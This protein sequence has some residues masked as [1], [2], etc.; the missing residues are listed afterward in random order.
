MK[1][2][3]VSKLYQDAAE[4]FKRFPFVILFSILGSVTMIS[5]IEWEPSGDTFLSKAT[6]VFALGI[7]FLLSLT[8]RS[9]TLNLS[10]GKNLLIQAAG[11]AFLVG[12]YLY[13]PIK[14]SESDATRYA[15]FALGFH[16]LV[17]FAAFMSIED[18]H[19][20]NIDA[21]WRFNKLFFLRILTSVLFSGVLFI[22]LAVAIFAFDKLFNVD[23]DGKIYPQLFFFI[24]GVFNTWFFLSGIPQNISFF[25]EE[26]IYPK[27]L[28]IF[29]QFVLLPLVSV[30][31]VILYLYMGKIIF[32]W[33]LPYGWVSYLI[34][35]FSIA[36]I[37]SLLL[38]YPIR[39]YQENRWIRI[40]SHS[41][42]IALLP[43]IVLLFVAILTRLFEYG[44]TEK[45]YFVFVLACWLAFISI[46]FLLSKTKNIKLIPISLFI[47]CFGTSFGPWGAFSVSQRSQT[48]RLENLLVKNNILVNGKIVPV[49]EQQPS[50]ADV[51]NISSIVDFLADRHQI[52]SLQ[53]WFDTNLD[54]ITTKESYTQSTD[55]MKL[56]GMKYLPYYREYS[57]NEMKQYFNYNFEKTNVTKVTGYDYF[58]D[59]SMYRIKDNNNNY[60][61]RDS[62]FTYQLDSSNTLSL[63]LLKEPCMMSVKFNGEEISLY[64]FSP[65]IDTLKKD[66]ISSMLPREKGIIRINNNKVDVIININVIGGYH[67][68][69]K[70]ILNSLNGDMF[71]TLKK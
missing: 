14:I 49:K 70:S 69:N 39:N 63:S 65:M 11:I 57:D 32:Q 61:F 51:G 37:L 45:R 43:L 13:L 5:L 22:G 59:L 58:V 25:Y 42:Y 31:V 30:Y 66:G 33:T 21:F 20:K 68:G 67:E 35:C 15:L 8:L 27:A 52:K 54:S 19:Q 34:L 64:N 18:D 17:S 50:N 40:F 6:M 16:F 26:E 47:L 46:Y 10:K 60:E 41:F 71:V 1:I 53:D 4:T 55:I 3:S 28:K 9:E 29:T 23:I 12:Y 44:V 36:G 62:V 7:S 38:I 24:V 48:T 56:M 2:P